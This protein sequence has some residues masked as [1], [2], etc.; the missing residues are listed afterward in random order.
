MCRG[1]KRTR[2]QYRIN[3][4][5]GQVTIPPNARVVNATGKFL[6]PGLWESQTAYSWYF[7]EA[8]LNHGITSSIDVGTEAEVAVPHRDA[9]LHGKDLAP[10][11][12]SSSRGGEC[13]RKSS[14]PP[15]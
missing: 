1:L 10:V 13:R 14:A 15:S 2:L 3:S 12:R 9:V 8:M 4:V 7:G 6:L 5:R 11:Q